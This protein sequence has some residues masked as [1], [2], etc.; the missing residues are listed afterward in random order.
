MQQLSS[1]T[2]LACLAVLEL[3]RRHGHPEPVRLRTISEA[4]EISAQFLVQILLQL[5]RAGIVESIRGACGG[6]RLTTSPDCIS[7]LDVWVALEGP[8]AQTTV[9]TDNPVAR[10]IK[11]V[12]TTLSDEH[13]RRLAEMTFDKLVAASEESS[14]A[15]MY[16]I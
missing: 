9:A 13:Q 11:E 1:K 12:W 15:D 3:S 8:P 2:Q 4:H 16:Y 6:Y 7:L 14:V 5:K 10:V